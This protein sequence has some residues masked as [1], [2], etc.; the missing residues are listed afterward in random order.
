MVECPRETVRTNSGRNPMAALQRFVEHS[1]R[2]ATVVS[3]Q[4]HCTASS[5]RPS[6]NR[7]VNSGVLIEH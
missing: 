1:A 5:S 3:D 7:P 4:V 6:V 2:Y